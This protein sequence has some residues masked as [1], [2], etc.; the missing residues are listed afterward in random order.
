MITIPLIDTDDFENTTKHGI[1]KLELMVRFMSVLEIGEST[2][3]KEFNRFKSWMVEKL[4]RE[5][6]PQEEF[7]LMQGI[8]DYVK[9]DPATNERFAAM[10]VL[11]NM[12]FI[13]DEASVGG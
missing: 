11:F 8:L 12:E 9:S 13:K 6:T 2:A 3:E 1:E 7:D 10:K 5:I 4:K